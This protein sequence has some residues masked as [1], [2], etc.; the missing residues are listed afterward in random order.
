MKKSKLPLPRV[1]A[2]LLLFL[3]P[4]S[5]AVSIV[6]TSSILTFIGLSL[7]FW[8]ALL[9]Y[10]APSKHVKLDLLNQTALSSLANLDKILTELK[11]RGKG[12]YLPP[13]YLSDLESGKVFL[14]SKA[15]TTV[16]SLKEIREETVFLKNPNGVCLIP[17]GL[18]LTQLFEKELGI[19]FTKADVKDLQVKLPK[20]FIEDLEIAE[21]LKIE[22]EHDQ[23]EVEI[24]GSVYQDL[25]QEVKKFQR[26][27][28][29]LGSPI[30]SALACALAKASGNPVVIENEVINSKGRTIK[31][32]YRIFKEET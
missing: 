5:L 24:K 15:E 9:F 14:S 28:D 20:L 6:C 12:I 2:I 26:V 17:P 16:P 11:C 31:V 4:L 27:S 25:C 22:T 30:A 1:I 18:A 23:V 8:G 3:G 7:T 13:K 29:L 10:V 21:D 32:Q 19:S